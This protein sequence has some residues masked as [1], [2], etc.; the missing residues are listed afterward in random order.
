M[1]GLMKLGQHPFPG[2][3][4][5]LVAARCQLQCQGLDKISVNALPSWRKADTRATPTMAFRKCSRAPNAFQDEFEMAAKE[6]QGEAAYNWA[7]FCLFPSVFSSL[8]IV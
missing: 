6:I 5:A 7:G 2:H 1:A 4:E 3:R 8:T